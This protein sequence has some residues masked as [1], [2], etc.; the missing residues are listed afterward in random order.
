MKKD[1]RNIEMVKSITILLCTTLWPH[2]HL[3][4]QLPFSFGQVNYYT[5]T[6]GPTLI[7][8]INHHFLLYSIYT[9][10][11]TQRDSFDILQCPTEPTHDRKM[12]QIHLFFEL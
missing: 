8:Q 5:T 1:Q 12:C 7:S 9:N 10:P 4:N 6:Y 2:P 11:I 3:S